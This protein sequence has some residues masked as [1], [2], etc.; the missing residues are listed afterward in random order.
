MI[1]FAFIGGTPFLLVFH[2]ISTPSPPSLIITFSLQTVLS[3]YVCS[4]MVLLLP[5]QTPPSPPLAVN[6][7]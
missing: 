7:E 2:I 6:Y 3:K 4:S 5:Q 1:C